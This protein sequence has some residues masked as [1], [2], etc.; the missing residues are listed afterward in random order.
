MT[1]SCPRIN[2]SFPNALVGNPQQIHL[3]TG[4]DKAMIGPPTKTFGGDNSRITPKQTKPTLFSF[5]IL[6]FVVGGFTDSINPCAL[7]TIAFF[8]IVLL[9]FLNYRKVMLVFG[10]SFILGVLGTIFFLTMGWGDPVRSSAVFF[11]MCRI[12]YLIVALIALGLG[13]LSLRDW[14]F[15][16]K[17]KSKNSLA[18]KFPV[19]S[20]RLDQMLFN[21]SSDWKSTLWFPLVCIAAGILTAFLMSIYP[22]QTYIS[23]TVY[24]LNVQQ[25]PIVSILSLFLYSLCFI[26]PLVFSFVFVILSLQSKSFLTLTQRYWAGIKIIC[27]AVFFAVGLGLMY[28][29]L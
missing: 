25:Q 13:T 5:G 8:V 11:L 15:Y 16:K 10:G 29:F 12:I 4:P 14:W 23:M 28:A 9:F 27:S 7:T 22:E 6:P 21:L 20:K 24:T 1:R 3:G 2:L 26:F 18:M 19:I 17:T